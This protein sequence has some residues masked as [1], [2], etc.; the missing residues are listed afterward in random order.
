MVTKNSAGV[1]TG[2]PVICTGPSL[3]VTC[4]C[5]TGPPVSRGGRC[6]FLDALASLELVIRVTDQ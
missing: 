2:P 5:R 6:L 4:L 3:N 1:R